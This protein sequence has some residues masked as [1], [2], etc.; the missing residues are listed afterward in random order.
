MAISEPRVTVFIYIYLYIANIGIFTNSYVRHIFKLRNLH[1]LKLYILLFIS[2]YRLL[3]IIIITAA[4][5][6]W[7]RYQWYRTSTTSFFR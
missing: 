7:R 4:W 2:L 6:Y 1:S 3:I 5:W